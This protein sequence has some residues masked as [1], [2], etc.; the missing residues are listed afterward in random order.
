MRSQMAL[1]WIAR[2]Q[3]TP[4]AVKK[5]LNEAEAE[6]ERARHVPALRALLEHA[7]TPAT[8]TLLTTG[9][10]PP[11]AL[12]AFAEDQLANPAPPPA[13]ADLIGAFAA[14]SIH[15]TAYA[16]ARDISGEETLALIEANPMAGAEA[17]PIMPD[18]DWLQLQA[19]CDG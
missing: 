19:I 6:L 9:A 5:E 15:S 17:V 3:E 1:D 8:A 11:V 2:E 10:L 7:G 4:G 16:R 18:R 14:S 13:P 12:D